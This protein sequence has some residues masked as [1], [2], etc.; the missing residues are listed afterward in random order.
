MNDIIEGELAEPSSKTEI[1]KQDDSAGAVAVFNPLDA[2]PINFKRQLDTRQENYDTLQMHLQ[3]VL[4]ADKDFG[5]IH[6]KKGCDNK[7]TCSNDYHFSGYMLFAPGADK[8]L[9]ILGLAVHYPDLQD[10]K[11]ATLKG[12]EIQEVIAD[13]Q[14]LGLNEQVIAEGAG[15]C[16]RGEVNGSLNNCIKRACKRARLDAVLRLPV[17]SAL[18]EGDFLEK[19]AA[20]QAIK[21]QRTAAQREQTIKNIWD[22]GAKLRACPIGNE[23]KGKPWHDIE[24]HTLEWLVA[25]VTDKPDVTRAA[26][27]ELTKRVSATDP[28]SIRTPSAPASDEDQQ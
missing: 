7:Y 22:T 19:M 6:V 3:G 24:T 5:K 28:G 16:A 13:C 15:A 25:N 23:I 14:I 2:E 18:F 26:A 11:R 27:E 21:A 20:A 4:V 9:G 10:Y 1:V 12:L 8:I 17:V